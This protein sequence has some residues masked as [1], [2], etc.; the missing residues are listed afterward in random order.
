VGLAVDRSMTTPDSVIDAGWPS[1]SNQLRKFRVSTR[2]LPSQPKYL[3]SSLNDSQHPS[4]L[5][6]RHLQACLPQRLCRSSRQDLK[7]I[8]LPGLRPLR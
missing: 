4:H 5:L 7:P 2:S 6:N 3:Q 8:Q 1:L